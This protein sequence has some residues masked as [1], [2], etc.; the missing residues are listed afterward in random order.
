ME[1]YQIIKITSV[2]ATLM[3]ENAYVKYHL[4]KISAK[5]NA[6]PD[7]NSVKAILIFIGTDCI[8]FEGCR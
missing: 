6:R 7:Y 3:Q 5:G 1:Y 2:W 8:V 4:W